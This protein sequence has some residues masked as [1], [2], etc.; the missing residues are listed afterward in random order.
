MIVHSAKEN[1]WKEKSRMVSEGLTVSTRRIVKI[2][3][4]RTDETRLLLPSSSAAISELEGD[5]KL[6]RGAVQSRSSS[7]RTKSRSKGDDHTRYLN[8]LPLDSEAIKT[9][10]AEFNDKKKPVDIIVEY[11]FPPR[12][13][14][15]EYK[16]FLKLNGMDNDGIQRY[17]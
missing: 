13:V 7:P 15:I 16:R 3:A 11:G 10:Y 17:I 6:R 4:E 1:V 14:E 5:R 12:A 9:L 8:I 2:S